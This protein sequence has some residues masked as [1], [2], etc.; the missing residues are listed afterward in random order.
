MSSKKNV[1]VAEECFFH[2]G[3]FINQ[4]MW[5]QRDTERVHE[6]SALLFIGRGHD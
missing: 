6:E 1:F 2:V 4:Y 5:V 3:L